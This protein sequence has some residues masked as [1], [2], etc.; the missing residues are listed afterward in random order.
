METDFSAKLGNSNAFSAQNQVVSK[1]KTKKKVFT[2]IKTDFS[3]KI[4]NSYAFSG[5]ITTCTL[6]LWHPIFYGG[7]CFQFFTKNRPQNHLKHAILHTSQ[8]NGGARAPP[9][10]PGYATAP[11]ASPSQLPVG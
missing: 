2:E 3:A 10:P 8:A 11:G 5:R 1:T 4:A 6:Q 9:G 7:G